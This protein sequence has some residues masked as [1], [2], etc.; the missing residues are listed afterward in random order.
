M[1]EKVLEGTVSTTREYV[2]GNCYIDINTVAWSRRR[3]AFFWFDLLSFR[4]R[5][6][7]WSVLRIIMVDFKA[8]IFLHFYTNFALNFLKNDV[9]EMLCIY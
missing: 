1:N 8:T 3:T 9:H 5:A 6:I 4:E 2:T 7:K